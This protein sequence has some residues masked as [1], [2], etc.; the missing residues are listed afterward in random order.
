MYCSGI[1]GNEITE[2]DQTNRDDQWYIT[3]V[4][5]GSWKIHENS[6]PYPWRHISPQVDIVMNYW[7]IILLSHK[8]GSYSYSDLQKQSENCCQP[9][10]YTVM[11]RGSMCKWHVITNLGIGPKVGAPLSEMWACQGSGQIL[12]SRLGI[13]ILGQINRSCFK[14]EES[15]MLWSVFVIFS[16]EQHFFQDFVEMAVRNWIQKE[17]FQRHFLKISVYFT[18]SIH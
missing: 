13:F 5:I 12:L 18:C 4:S 1:T 7:F 6:W 2:R 8:W 17:I 15:A 9:N 16:V 11:T 3:S 14:R 10:P